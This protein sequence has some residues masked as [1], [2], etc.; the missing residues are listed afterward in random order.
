MVEGVEGLKGLRL[1]DW[2]LQGRD[3]SLD[4]VGQRG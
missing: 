3:T 1:P 2:E 4:E